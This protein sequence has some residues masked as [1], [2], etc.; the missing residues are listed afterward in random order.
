MRPLLVAV[1]TLDAALLGLTELAWLTARLPSGFALGAW[2]TVAAAAVTTPLLVRAA[3]R[4]RPGTF[5]AFLPLTAWVAVVVLAG[6][7]SPTGA[8]VLPADGRA[9]LLVAAG[10]LPGV[11]AVA[12]PV[13]DGQPPRG[14]SPRA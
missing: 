10:L 1:L 11:A 13:R 4:A 14:L 7:W 2:V 5:V 12:R 3:D 8:G 9:L 6:I